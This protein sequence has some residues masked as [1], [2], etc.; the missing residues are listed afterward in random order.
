[1]EI[2]GLES[3]EPEQRLNMHSGDSIG[4]LTSHFFRNVSTGVKLAL[5]DLYQYDFE[6]FNYDPHLY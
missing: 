1:M 6:M 2:L 3:Q 4:D 5:I